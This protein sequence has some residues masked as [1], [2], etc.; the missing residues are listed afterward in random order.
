LKHVLDT[1]PE[2]G[3]SEY[4][5]KKHESIDA[6]VIADYHRFSRHIPVYTKRSHEWQ[7]KF[8]TKLN[9][10]VC[11]IKNNP[12]LRGQECAA[13]LNEFRTKLD[14]DNITQLLNF[15]VIGIEAISNP[16][17]RGSMA[18]S[19]IATYSELITK[20]QFLRLMDAVIASM[21][22]DLEDLTK[23]PDSLASGGVGL[24]DPL[25]EEDEKPKPFLCNPYLTAE[26]YNRARKLLEQYIS[27][28][29]V[30]RD[31]FIDE[32]QA[33]RLSKIAIRSQPGVVDFKAVVDPAL[34]EAA[35][36]TYI[37]PTSL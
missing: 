35:N 12:V 33:I 5:E 19:L 24:F 17:S 16:A 36:R 1:I 10:Y 6:K 32:H 13:F 31:R 9:I 15:V 30:S 4:D 21:E 7:K 18:E 14:E 2:V 37:N 25:P 22:Y 29:S 26:V 27:V 8:L 11:N 3:E 23:V 34:T 20:D 28:S